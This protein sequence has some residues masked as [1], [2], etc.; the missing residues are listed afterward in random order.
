MSFE[1]T[2]RSRANKNLGDIIEEKWEIIGKTVIAEPQAGDPRRGV[3]PRFGIYDYDVKPIVQ[4]SL[5]KTPAPARRKPSE[6]S[7]G[8][9]R[10]E[11]STVGLTVRRFS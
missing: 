6:P 10:R 9:T 5:A 8:C 7:A 11:A 1:K 4:Q 2:I 3:A